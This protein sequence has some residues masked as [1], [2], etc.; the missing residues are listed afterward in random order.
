MNVKTRIAAVGAS[1]ALVV[2][3]AACGGQDTPSA[4]GPN[5]N[6][7][8]VEFAQMMIPHHEGAIAMADLAVKSAT[9][10]PVKDLGRRISAAQGPQIKELTSWLK[11]WG[12]GSKAGA[13]DMAGMQMGDS[14]PDGAMSELG[15]TA[16]PSF[17]RR[18]LELMIDHHRGALDMAKAELT[19]GKNPQARKLARVI[20]DAQ[21][22][23]IAEMTGMLADL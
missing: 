3:L 23:E 6:D 15:T 5:H 13:G 8:D 18:F 12:E 20:I 17:D 4:T 22:S 21:T 2:V 9:T 7:A 14:K 1:L 11:A 19:G 16:G 10:E